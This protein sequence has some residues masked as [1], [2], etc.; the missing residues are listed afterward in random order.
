MLNFLKNL[1]LSKDR[2][3]FINDP[4]KK[5][6]NAYSIFNNDPVMKPVFDSYMK[7]EREREERME[8]E[9]QREIYQKYL[10]SRIHGSFLKDFY[11]NRY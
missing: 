2:K 6:Y 7:R 8:L 4:Y 11:S 10:E 5:L 9:R 3:I 1:G